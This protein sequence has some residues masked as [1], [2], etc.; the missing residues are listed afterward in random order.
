MFFA[1]WAPEVEDLL[2][3]MAVAAVVGASCKRRISLLRRA[4]YVV[5]RSLLSIVRML[6]YRGSIRLGSLIGRLAW[7]LCGGLRRHTRRNLELAYGGSIS[8]GEAERIARGAFDT[9]GRNITD[10]ANLA[11]RPYRGLVIENAD[12]LRAAYDQGRGVILVS[13][14]MGCFSRLS[15]VPLFLGMKGASIM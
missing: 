10:V 11:S 12:V 1:D 3:P 9:L 5:V 6:S 15:A 7:L 2:Y 13:A 8:S 14:H 4:E